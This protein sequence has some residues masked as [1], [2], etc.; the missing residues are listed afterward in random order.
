[1]KASPR[2]NLVNNSLNDSDESLYT[3]SPTATAATYR[4]EIRYPSILV[5]ITSSLRSN[6]FITDELQLNPD[7][8]LYF[9]GVG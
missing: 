7:F 1:M 2:Y 4:R 3:V 9:L 8:K 5:L 6:T